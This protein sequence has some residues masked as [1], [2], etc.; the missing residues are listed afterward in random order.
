MN[1]A[2]STKNTTQKGRE[3]EKLACEFL[4]QQGFEILETNFYTALGEIDI[5]AKKKNIW[6]FVEVKSGSGFEPI[7]NLTP[8]KLKHITQSIK[9]YLKNLS[10]T[11]KYCLS[12]VILSR[13]GPNEDYKI[14]FLENL[15]IF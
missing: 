12:A 6:H 4:Q 5:I 15:T 3:A 14:E 9:I 8:A 2:K 11:P 10:H 1:P 13:N 7:Y